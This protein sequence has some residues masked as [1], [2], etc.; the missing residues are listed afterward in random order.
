MFWDATSCYRVCTN[1]INIKNASSSE[2]N[3][4]NTENIIGLMTEW[5][6]DSKNIKNY[7]Y[8]LWWIYAI[9]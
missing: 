6:K 5:I 4:K 2:F 9:G 8:R 1:V 7:K 3:I